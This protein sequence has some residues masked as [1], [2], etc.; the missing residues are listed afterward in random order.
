MSLP[1]FEHGD[2]LGDGAGLPAQV[3]LGEHIEHDL[4]RGRDLDVERAERAQAPAYAEVDRDS[5]GHLPQ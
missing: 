1:A 3:R 4:A 2:L 5:A